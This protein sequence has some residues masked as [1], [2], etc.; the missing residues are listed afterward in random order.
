M[1]LGMRKLLALV[2]III[3]LPIIMIMANFVIDELRFFMSPCVAWGQTQG[4]ITYP[5]CSGTSQ[6]VPE[7]FLNLA[8]IPG[9]IL[10]ASVVGFIG[11]VVRRQALLVAGFVVLSLESSVL[12]FDRLF[13]LTVPP[14]VY[15]LWLARSNVLFG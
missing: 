9:G 2:A 6:T 5:G 3:V 12:L 14:A 11:A 15:F 10:V 13:L 8:L 7:F 1:Q 4:G